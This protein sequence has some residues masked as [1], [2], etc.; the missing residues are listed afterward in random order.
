MKMYSEFLLRFRNQ[1]EIQ[2]LC[3]K[4]LAKFNLPFIKGSEKL[5]RNIDLDEYQIILKF[6]RNLILP[7]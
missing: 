3:K 4:I 5:S 1:D 6:L 2:D 7:L